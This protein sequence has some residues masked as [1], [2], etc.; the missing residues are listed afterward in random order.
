MKKTLA[1]ILT[2]LI[3]TLAA[4]GK[5]DNSSPDIDTSSSEIISSAHVSSN[6]ETSSD[7][8]SSVTSSEAA[9]S[10]TSKPN[11]TNVKKVNDSTNIVFYDESSKVLV[12][13]IGLVPIREAYEKGYIRIKIINGKAHIVQS[14]NGVDYIQSANIDTGISYDGESPIIY[15]YPDGT[16]GTEKRDG[17]KYEFLPGIFYTY[18]VMVDGVG[19]KY[20]TTCTACGKSVS[21]KS[22]G[23]NCTQYRHDFYCSCCGEFVRAY[24][25]HTCAKI[26]TNATL[27]CIYCGKIENDGTNGTCVR[28]LMADV[29]CP[30][31]GKHVKVRTCH[32]CK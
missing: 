15:T 24:T 31:C 12:K 19:R 6:S 29:D 21:T 2:F 32:T 20:G 30:N 25:C 3:L 10:V 14:M 26:Y 23:E 17:A 9:P 8:V 16:T 28:W 11:K 5:T 4:C 7:E 1:L 27:Y 18:E 13:G 22:L